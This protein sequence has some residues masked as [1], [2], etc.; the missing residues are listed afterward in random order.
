MIIIQPKIITIVKLKLQN[1]IFCIGHK[2]A[3]NVGNSTLI[4]SFVWQKVG[5]VTLLAPPGKKSS[6]ATDDVD[7]VYLSV[8]ITGVA[9]TWLTAGLISAGWK[10]HS[11]D[12]DSREHDVIQWRIGQNYQSV[13]KYA[14]RFDLGLHLTFR[15]AELKTRLLCQFSKFY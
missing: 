6:Y 5:N 12:L 15:V 13:D 10:M 11:R 2:T 3:K 8:D 14:Q 9:I 1:N 7:E 4:D